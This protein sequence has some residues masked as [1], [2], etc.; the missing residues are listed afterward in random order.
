MLSMM[1]F[2]RPS[3]VS[4]IHR[5]RSRRAPMTAI[6]S[7]NT[8]CEGVIQQFQLKPRRASPQPVRRAI[9]HASEIGNRPWNTRSGRS[10]AKGP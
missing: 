5:R 1:A 2:A 8:A 3:M 9:V 7:P 6:R 10:W 4:A